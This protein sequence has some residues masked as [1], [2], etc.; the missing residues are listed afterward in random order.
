MISLKSHSWAE[1]PSF[2]L[3]LTSEP[4]HIIPY[5]QKSSVASYLLNSLYRNLYKYDEEKGLIPDLVKDCQQNKKKINCNLKKNIKWSDGTPITAKDFIDTYKRILTV[6][7]QAESPQFLFEIKNAELIFNKKLPLDKLGVTSR[8]PSEIQFE[9]ENNSNK[10]LF[11]L[12]LLQTAPV[13]TVNSV[14]NPQNK[15]SGPY[16][17]NIWQASKKIILEPNQYYWGGNKKRPNLELFFIQEDTVALKLY[18]NN[19]LD[20]LRRLPV[21]YI[22]KYKSSPEYHWIPVSRFDFIAFGPQLQNFPNVRKALSEAINYEE[23]Q[24]LWSSDDRPGCPGID[25]S[26]YGNK[27]L[28]ID[29]KPAEAIK[30]LTNLTNIPKLE[31]AYSIQGG[32]NH[33]ITAEFLALQWLKNLK[34]NIEIKSYENKVFLQKLAHHPPSIFRKGNSLDIPF[35]ESGLKYFDSEP[36]RSMYDKSFYQLLAQLNTANQKNERQKL[37]Y[38]TIKYLLDKHWI[39]PT[40]R[41]HFSVLSKPT[42]KAWKL[43]SFNYLFLEDLIYEQAK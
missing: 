2:R 36:Y 22:P 3:H 14:S 41:I 28:C 4:S 27:N 38:E 13:P 9:L 16:K 15:F 10:F 37:C 34:I 19:Q 39:I 23:L 7:E 20:F 21:Q 12:S 30:L 1:T 35:C 6:E 40:G 29:H 32:D 31:F 25:P 17:I 42:F 8:S 11:Y 43:N 33:K 18:E 5:K 24:K 26:W